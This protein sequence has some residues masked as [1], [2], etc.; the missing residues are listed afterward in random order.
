MLLVADAIAL[1]NGFILR[2]EHAG[3]GLTHL[4]TACQLLRPQIVPFAE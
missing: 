3:Q 2:P 4:P 1:C